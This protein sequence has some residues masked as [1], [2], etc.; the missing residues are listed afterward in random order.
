MGK[1]K[2]K[3]KEMKVKN[4]ADM[5]LR[6]EACLMWPE[7]GVC[8]EC[9]ERHPTMASL[10]MPPA[11]ATSWIFASTT[12]DKDKKDKKKEKTK[13]KKKMM[14]V[15]VCKKCSSYHMQL[16][17]D[18]CE[19]KNIKLAEQWAEETVSALELSGNQVVN[20]IYESTMDADEKE[21]INNYKDER[22]EQNARSAFVSMKYQDLDYFSED[23]Y[24]RYWKSRAY[25][26]KYGTI[27][28]FADA[29]MRENKLRRQGQGTVKRVSSDP[30]MLALGGDSDS[31]DEEEEGGVMQRINQNRA[32]R[33]IEADANTEDVPDVGGGGNDLGDGEAPPDAANAVQAA[34]RRQMGRMGRRGSVGGGGARRS[35]VGINLNGTGPG[36]GGGG[37]VKPKSTGNLMDLAAGLDKGGSAHNSR[38]NGRFGAVRGKKEGLD[39]AGSTHS[40]RSTRTTRT[41]RTTDDPAADGTPAPRRRA[42]LSV[43]RSV[44]T[45]KAIAAAAADNDNGETPST[46]RRQKTREKASLSPVRKPPARTQSS[47]RRKAAAKEEGRDDDEDGKANADG[48]VL[49]PR[50]KSRRKPENDGEE[51][52]AETEK[53]DED[54]KKLPPRTRSKRRT[55]RVGLDGDSDK[56]EKPKGESTKS[57][58]Q[59]SRSRRSSRMT[60]D[61]GDSDNDEQG[62]RESTKS[63]HQ[64]SRSR[65][66]SRMSLDVGD[67]DKDEQGTKE[68]SGR[69]PARTRSKHTRRTSRSTIDGDNS[70][71]EPA[72]GEDA[73]KLP[74]RTRSKRSGSR[75]RLEG[76]NVDDKEAKKAAKATRRRSK[77]NE[78]DGDSRHGNKS[79]SD[80]DL[81]DDEDAKKA[82]KA[83]AT[84]RRSKGNELDGDSGHGNKLNSDVDLDEDE[85]ARKAAKARAN[86]RRS[87]SGLIDGNSGHCKSKSTRKRSKSRERIMDAGEKGED[88]KT[89]TDAAKRK[90]KRSSKLEKLDTSDGES[91]D[92]P[93]SASGSGYKSKYQTGSL[94]GSVSKF[95]AA[96]SEVKDEAGDAETVV[97]EAGVKKTN[98][99]AK[100]NVGIGKIASGE[101]SIRDDSESLSYSNKDH[102][103]PTADLEP[104]HKSDYKK[105][106]RG[107]F[108]LAKLG[109]EPTPEDLGYGDNTA[110]IKR[111]PSH[112][113]LGY[114]DDTESK[115]KESTKL[116]PRQKSH[117]RGNEMSRRGSRTA[118]SGATRMRRSHSMA[119]GGIDDATSKDLDRGTSHTRRMR[120]STSM[121]P[122]GTSTGQPAT[123]KAGVGKDLDKGSSHTRRMRRS[124]SMAHGGTNTS[125]PSP[126]KADTA[127]DLD[128]GT[129]HRRM[130]RSQSMAHGSS[131]GDQSPDAHKNGKSKEIPRES[132]RGSRSR[133]SVSGL[134]DRAKEKANI[135]KDAK[136]KRMNGGSVGEEANPRLASPVA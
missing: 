24:K 94:L 76:D 95:V 25:P 20:A 62:T 21:N 115:P 92:K 42:S 5:I 69:S 77:G 125:Q 93:E 2:E 116:P 59:R 120:R 113:D 54:A 103:E 104:F 17:R 124:T 129:S 118:G 37:M 34:A 102:S 70:D 19:V 11:V 107:G 74:S 55:S 50:R 121:A 52:P 127:K 7:N 72:K 108:D 39:A 126:S 46:P 44:A 136:Q 82:A 10:L 117:G 56:E 90:S 4:Q 13:D 61:V 119:H 27:M 68:G 114:G 57:T 81:D 96:N 32:A 99:K 9:P 71:E 31:E 84:R 110:N 41:S 47:S 85:E 78:L 43:R 49:S 128:K 48:E 123:S 26:K 88:K 112:E 30:N 132:V 14:G 3:K 131:S 58:H 33:A 135:V 15:F 86:R 75:S 97:S 38:L 134:K 51:N 111:A 89:D 53:K 6:L 80:V 45:D 130:R 35:T 101:H 64:R 122:G 73:K 23:T 36:T 106:Y 18:V 63:T 67:S 109:Q 83:R 87:K 29:A 1:D 16:G 40:R 65:R 79:N 66:S 105:K 12:A 98:Y 8:A 91:K 28:S 100:Y 133:S 22:M 60:L